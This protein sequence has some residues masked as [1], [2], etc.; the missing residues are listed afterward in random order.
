MASCAARSTVATQKQQDLGAWTQ[1]LQAPCPL[2]QPLPRIGAHPLP[3][4]LHCGCHFHPNSLRA[5]TWLQR[6][7]GLDLKEQCVADKLK[8]L[9]ERRAHSDLLNLFC[10]GCYQ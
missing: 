10:Q 4:P 5:N 9:P 7:V 6:I 8:G 2:T 1:L 3:A